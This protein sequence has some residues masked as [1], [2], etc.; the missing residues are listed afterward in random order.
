MKIHVVVVNVKTTKILAMK[1]T[2]QHVYDSK[3]LPRRVNSVM[4]LVKKIPIGKLIAE[5]GAC[6][7]NDIFKCLADNGISCIKVRKNDRV[8]WKIGNIPRNLSVLSHRNDL[9]K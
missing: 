3:A 4:I 8:R 5:D 7:S 2:D 6:Y 9:Q 1:V